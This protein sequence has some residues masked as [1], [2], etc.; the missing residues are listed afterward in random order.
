M[1]NAKNAKNAK[2]IVCE[3][4]DFVCFKKSNYEKHLNTQKHYLAINGT[5]LEKRI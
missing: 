1:E 5:I 3:E 4:C 2:Q